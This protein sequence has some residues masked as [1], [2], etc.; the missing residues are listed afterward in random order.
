MQ[1]FKRIKRKIIPRRGP[2]MQFRIKFYASSLI[3]RYLCY[4]LFCCCLFFKGAP[5]PAALGNFSQVTI[6]LILW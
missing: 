3:C 4:L 5:L 1:K 2:G 6:A